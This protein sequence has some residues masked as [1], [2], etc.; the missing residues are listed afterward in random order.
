MLNLI[1]AV[2]GSRGFTLA[3]VGQSRLQS[4]ET[5]R[6]MLQGKGLW[7]CFSLWVNTSKASFGTMGARHS[8]VT[9]N[10]AP[11]TV[12][13]GPGTDFATSLACVTLLYSLH[14][15]N[16]RSQGE[17]IW[18]GT[19]RV[20]G[21]RGRNSANVPPPRPPISAS[22]VEAPICHFNQYMINLLLTENTIYRVVC[23]VVVYLVC[24]VPWDVHL[25]WPI[26]GFPV[27][28]HILTFSQ[29]S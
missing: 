24:Y 23:P 7:L 12:Y 21:S 5:V 20:S 13:T 28:C 29:S 26:E 1:I 4:F 25:T 15:D 8:F 17:L 16:N 27:T 14:H 3:R 18:R 19:A 9:P 11:M 6:E 22:S 2:T 10:L